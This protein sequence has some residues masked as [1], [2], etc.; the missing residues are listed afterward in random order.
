MECS[1]KKRERFTTLRQYRNFARGPIP[2]EWM[3]KA[4]RLSV[5]AIAIGFVLWKLSYQRKLWGESGL[6]N[7]SLPVR[8]TNKMVEDWGISRFIKN[9]TLKQI[10]QEGLILIRQEKGSSP[11]I[12][13]VDDFLQNKITT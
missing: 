12:I 3:R 6:R 11:D 4:G 13:I 1:D 9:N 5:N 8:L 10:E 7:R 2:D